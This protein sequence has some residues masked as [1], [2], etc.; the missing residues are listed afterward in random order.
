MREKYRKKLWLKINQNIL[1]ITD[2]NQR[3]LVPQTK[4]HGLWC[5]QTYCF[6]GT[7]FY[8][9][10]C[11]LRHTAQ[12]PAQFNIILSVGICFSCCFFLP[13]MIISAHVILGYRFKLGHS[14]ELASYE[15]PYFWGWRPGRL[16][17]NGSDCPALRRGSLKNLY[18]EDSKDEA[19][20]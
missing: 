9:L 7:T 3:P 14:L 16:W 13:G 8:T 5:L 18:C 4:S 11:F 15:M 12:S 2:L 10:P 6:R 1:I 17:S 19:P 20:L